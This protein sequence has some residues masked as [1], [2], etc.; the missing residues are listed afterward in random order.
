MQLFGREVSLLYIFTIPYLPLV[1]FWAL[2]FL[3][4]LFIWLL[5][6]ILTGGITLFFPTFRMIGDFMFPHIKVCPSGQN[7][8]GKKKY[9]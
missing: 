2:I 9:F 6:D 7:G 8:G 4:L 1:F 3:P 5:T